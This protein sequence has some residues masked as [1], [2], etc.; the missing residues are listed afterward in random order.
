MHEVQRRTA[1]EHG[2]GMNAEDFFYEY[3]GWGYDPRTE[4]PEEGRRRSAAELAR[5]ERWAREYGVTFVWSDDW[6]GDHSYLE[7][8]QSVETCEFVLA[9]DLDNEVLTSLGCV[10][11]ATDDYRRVVQAELAQ[12]IMSDPTRAIQIRKAMES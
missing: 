12:E 9:L 2:C 8:G 3:A 11:D 1:L 10:D 5:A 6:D 7:Y 4:T